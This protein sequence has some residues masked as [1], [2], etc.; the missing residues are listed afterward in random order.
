MLNT[1]LTGSCKIQ[2]RLPPLGSHSLQ[3]WRCQPSAAAV[4]ASTRCASAL[5]E[6]PNGL[7]SRCVNIPVRQEAAQGGKAFPPVLTLADVFSVLWKTVTV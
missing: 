1:I 2:C 4:V 5:L 7:Q 6:F 3:E